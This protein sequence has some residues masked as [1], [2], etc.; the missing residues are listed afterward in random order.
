M[1]P[2][3][4]YFTILCFRSEY[5]QIVASKEKVEEFIEANLPGFKIQTVIGDGLCMIRSFQKSLLA[6]TGK[7][8]SINELTKE[9]RREILKNNAFYQDYSQEGVNILEEL[10]KFLDEPFKL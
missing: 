5:E 3:S 9:L 6:V 7:D 1:T 2:L 8:S 4:D 10:D